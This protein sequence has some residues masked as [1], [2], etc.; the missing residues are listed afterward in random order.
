MRQLGLASDNPQISLA[1]IMS[2]LIFH[3][4]ESWL[5]QVFSRALCKNWIIYMNG[6]PV[7]LTAHLLYFRY[8]VWNFPVVPLISWLKN[9]LGETSVHFTTHTTILCLHINCWGFPGGSVV[10]NLLA[11]AG[12][13]RDT[14]SI[15]GLGRSPGG[16]NG[17]QLQYS[18]LKNPMDR[19]AWCATY[20][21]WGRKE[22]DM[23]KHIN[24]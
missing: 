21:P 10:K 18:C 23:T 17:N 4:P 15:P 5:C 7:F 22:L 14:G 9:K 16:G 24:C 13:S 3:L 6:A 20:S 1:F 2:S 11:N 19:G 12:D 8:K